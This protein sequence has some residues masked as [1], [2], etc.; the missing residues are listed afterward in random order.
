M[1]EPLQEGFS[2]MSQKYRYVLVGGKLAG[3]AAEG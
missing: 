2:M 3:V 1:T